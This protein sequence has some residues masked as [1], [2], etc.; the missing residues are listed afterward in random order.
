MKIFN[1]YL[2]YCYC[3]D[4]IQ[5]QLHNLQVYI[6]KTFVRIWLQDDEGLKP[7]KNI[8]LIENNDEFYNF[9]LCR[10]KFFIP[11]KRLL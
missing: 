8:L 11:K 1:Y 5:I 3:K 6:C 7:T 2:G 10:L 4:Y 9:Q